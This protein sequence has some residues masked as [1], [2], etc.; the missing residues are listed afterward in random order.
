MRVGEGVV[1]FKHRTGPML[2][3]VDQIQCLRAQGGA[4][5]GCFLYLIGKPDAFQI[6]DAYDVARA[7]IQ[8]EC[9]YGDGEDEPADE[10]TGGES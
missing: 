3:A 4:N 6:L 2:V 5:V 8:A 10:E 1:E 7:A 9:G